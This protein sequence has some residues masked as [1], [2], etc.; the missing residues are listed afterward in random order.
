MVTKAIYTKVDG[1]YYKVIQDTNTPTTLFSM[2]NTHCNMSIDP[3]T[4]KVNSR[5]WVNGICKSLI[6]TNKEAYDEMVEELKSSSYLGI[7]QITNRFMLYIDYSVYDKN[8]NEVNH[9]VATKE[10]TPKDAIYPL[11]VDVDGNLMYK[12]IKQFTGEMNFAVK[13]SYPMGIMYSSNDEYKLIIND[14]VLYQDLVFTSR[15]SENV[16]YAYGSHTIASTLKNLKKVYSTA[17][18]NVSIA[19]VEVPFIPREISLKINLALDNVIVVYDE[20]VLSDI[21]VNNLI[22][23][24]KGNSECTC[25]DCGENCSCGKC[26]DSDTGSSNEPEI[27][28][29]EIYPKADSSRNPDNKNTYSYWDY[30]RAGV[31]GAVMVVED[32]AEDYDNRF[33]IHISMVIE[34][35]PDVEVGKFVRY[36]I[37]SST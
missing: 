25:E 28:E 2:P 33:Q 8:G 24:E 21:I 11:G 23:Y 15:S 20:S 14:L 13:N 31:P 17:D 29:G 37:V 22:E 19:A 7:A 6:S 34:D 32:D 30:S 18:N 35:I 27:P 12:Q 9:S 10:V 36:F 3:S 1:T 5:I 26:D 4:Q 16:C